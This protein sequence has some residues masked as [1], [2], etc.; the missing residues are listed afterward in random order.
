MEPNFVLCEKCGK[1]LIERL[2]NGLYRFLFGKTATPG[3]PVVDMT[4]HGNLKIKCLRRSC[5]HVNILNYFP[6]EEGKKRSAVNL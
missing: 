4:I 5:Q 3:G 2:P 6:F 1:K